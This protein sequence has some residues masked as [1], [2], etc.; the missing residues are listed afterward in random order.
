MIALDPELIEKVKAPI[1]EYLTKLDAIEKEQQDI[2]GEDPIR[3]SLDRLLAKAI[4]PAPSQQ[5]LDAIYALGQKRSESKAPPGYADGDK[6][7]TYCY[8][9]VTYSGKYGDL[10]IWRQIIDAAQKNKWKALIFVTDD[11]KEDWWVREEGQTLGPRPE[12]AAELHQLA[13]VEQFHMYETDQFLKR[14]KEHL[15]AKISDTSIEQVRE[16]NTAAGEFEGS[17]SHVDSVWVQQP[18]N[19]MWRARERQDIHV[20][21]LSY[22]SRR[23]STQRVLAQ[24]LSRFHSCF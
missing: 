15:A 18:D 17:T 11:R 22:L 3:T 4:G 10:T 7:D 16:S 24:R 13:G 9:D 20:A 1:D 5:E 23:F 8:G 21:V 12:L 14:A 2:R 6:E 19:A